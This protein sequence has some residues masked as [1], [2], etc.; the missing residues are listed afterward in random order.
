MGGEGPK[1]G[2]HSPSVTRSVTPE[3]R[4]QHAA[5]LV[6]EVVGSVPKAVSRQL[7]GQRSSLG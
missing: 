7:Q 6:G 4:A 2:N 3:Q 1:K 5:G